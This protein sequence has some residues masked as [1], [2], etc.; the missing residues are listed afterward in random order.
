MT[1]HFSSFSDCISPG[2]VFPFKENHHNSNLWEIGSV[3][4]TSKQEEFSLNFYLIRTK[5][6]YHWSYLHFILHP[7]LICILAISPFP[8]GRICNSWR[9]NMLHIMLSPWKKGLW[10]VGGDIWCYLLSKCWKGFR[11]EGKLVECHRK[12]YLC[13]EWGKTLSSQSSSW[14]WT[15]VTPPW[16][17]HSYI[18]FT[19]CGNQKRHRTMSVL[20]A[21]C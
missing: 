15:Q 8:W 17:T 3:L 4:F 7:S 13:S 12:P 10:A 18:P 1:W 19:D 11:A 5:R 6:L 2:D 16:W 20:G 21:K 9:K 14:L